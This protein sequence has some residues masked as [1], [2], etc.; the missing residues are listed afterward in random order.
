[1]KKYRLLNGNRF[2]ISYD[3]GKTWFLICKLLWT[4]ESSA[5]KFFEVLELL[6]KLGG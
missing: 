5:D 2:E 1:M 6:N 3:W 4:T